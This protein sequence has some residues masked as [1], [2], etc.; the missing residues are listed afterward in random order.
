MWNSLFFS[1]PSLFTYSLFAPYFISLFVL[2]IVSFYWDSS[3]FTPYWY[4]FPFFSHSYQLLLCLWLSSVFT[5]PLSVSPFHLVWPVAPYIKAEASLPFPIQLIKWKFISVLLSQQWG[6]VDHPN[7]AQEHQQNCRNTLHCVLWDGGAE[8]EM[9]GVRRN[10]HASAFLGYKSLSLEWSKP[11]KPPHLEPEFPLLY[12][13]W[14]GGE[15]GGYSQ[16]LCFSCSRECGCVFN[17]VPTLKHN[18]KNQSK[19]G[20]PMH[21]SSLFRGKP[22]TNIEPCSIKKCLKNYNQRFIF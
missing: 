6:C 4:F 2:L 5:R 13:Y 21:F 3:H 14:F 7:S 18:T 20:G 1:Y 11:F 17:T 15:M 8:K 16:P 10:C 22:C 19:S 12:L 9:E